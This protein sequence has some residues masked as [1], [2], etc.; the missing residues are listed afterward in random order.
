MAKQQYAPF[1]TF[2][3]KIGA[4]RPGAWFFARTLHHFDRIVLKLTGGRTTMAG[5]LAGLPI[6]DLT[7]IGAKSGLPRSLPLLCIRDKSNP[8]S[9]ALIASNYGQRHNPAWY[10]NL[11]ANPRARCSINGQVEEYIAHEAS[12][13]EYEQF[14]QAAEDTYRG[15]ALYKQ[16]AVNRRIPIMVMKRV[17]G[18]PSSS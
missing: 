7:V 12:G 6:V 15:Y 3:Q 18:R 13:K 11:K 17:P 14:W 16:R 10:Y 1:H 8:D 9:F 2:M 4:S 5:V